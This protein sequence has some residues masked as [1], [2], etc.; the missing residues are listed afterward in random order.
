MDPTAWREFRANPPEAVLID[1]SR[2]PSLGRDLA[3][4]LRKSRATRNVPLVFVDGAPDRVAGIKKLL[5][6]ASYTTWSK[7]R[8]ALKE[9][10]NRP[11]T[12]PLVPTS[13]FAGYAGTPLPRKLGIKRDSVV[14]LVGAPINFE[15]ILGDLPR[16]VKLKK[17]PRGPNDLVIWFTR[18]R[19]E[20]QGRAK[21]MAA[22]MGPDGLWILWPKKTSGLKSDLTPALVNMAAE[23]AGLVEYKVAS[24]DRTWT[25]FKYAKRKPAGKKAAGKKTVKKTVK[26]KAIRK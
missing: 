14:A 15:S 9:A 16:G 24:I 19:A 3:L 22:L 13:I 26:K 12:G 5:P 17:T 6:D 8:S 1:L 7:V 10:V 18:S 2:A 23:S 25:G 11:I 20:L 21:A 4:A